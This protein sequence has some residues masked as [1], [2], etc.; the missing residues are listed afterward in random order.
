MDRKVAK[1]LNGK[2]MTQDFYLYVVDA[3]CRYT[4]SI[5][6]GFF[7][8]EC[9]T[10]NTWNRNLDLTA[11]D[12]DRI[13]AE[14][15]RYGFGNVA[16]TGEQR[17]LV[18]G[19]SHTD[20]RLSDYQAHIV[21]DK[22]KI[23]QLQQSKS[24]IVQRVLD[25]GGREL[26]VFLLRDLR[27]RQLHLLSY[28]AVFDPVR[29]INRKLTTCRFELVPNEVIQDVLVKLQAYADALALDYAR[30]ELICDTATKEWYV[31]DINNSPGGGPLTDIAAPKIAKLIEQVCAV[32]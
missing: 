2:P 3:A 19:R 11:I 18:K 24:H 28:Y 13:A 16:Y 1:L 23:A 30:V 31:I 14:S 17:A 9:V 21:L 4:N 10:G 5:P 27:T 8:A 25:S 32:R 15:Q 29:N 12:K 7:E 6:D 22:E 26:N 20:S